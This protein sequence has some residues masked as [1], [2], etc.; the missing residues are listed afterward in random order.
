MKTIELTLVSGSPVT[1][2]V[3]HI[4]NIVD[5]GRTTTIND[6]THNNGG[7]HVQETYNEVLALIEVA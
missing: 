7:W 6:G 4:K 2:F 1:F 3:A 5:G